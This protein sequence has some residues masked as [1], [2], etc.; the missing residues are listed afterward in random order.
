MIKNILEMLD[1]VKDQKGKGRLT[2]I[3]LGRHKRPYL[4]NEVRNYIKLR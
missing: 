3:A 4:I 1:F 2:K